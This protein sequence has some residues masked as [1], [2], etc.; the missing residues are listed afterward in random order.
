MRLNDSQKVLLVILLALAMFA[1]GFRVH[2]L[3]FC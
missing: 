1:I 2:E 3:F